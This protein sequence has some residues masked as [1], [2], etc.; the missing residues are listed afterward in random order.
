[1]KWSI[2]SD[3]GI[4]REMNQDCVE[5]VYHDNMLLLCVCDGIGGAKA[6]EIA[7][8]M[9]CAQLCEAFKQQSLFSSFIQ[10]RTWLSETL[11]SINNAIFRQSKKN[12][13]Y[14]GMGTTMVAVIVWNNLAIALNI[15]DS[16][17]YMLSDTHEFMRI[18]FDH[19]LVFD[20]LQSGELTEEEAN[21]HPQRNYL[22]NALGIDTDVRIDFYDLSSEAWSMI[23]LCSDGLHGYV[24]EKRIKRALVNTKMN[25]DE[26]CDVLIGLANDVGGYDN[27]SVGLIERKDK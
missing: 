12:L 13:N 22:T 25:I 11:D 4:I 9:A 18:S 15:G 23:I 7:S 6:G 2:R 10:A 19:S 5:A 24:D 27:I 17:I 3:K 8:S 21:N 20:M 1:M 26:K 16:R 14:R